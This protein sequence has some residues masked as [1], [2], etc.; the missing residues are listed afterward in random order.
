MKN[1]RAIRIKAVDDIC[2]GDK[3][4]M[5]LGVL[6]KTKKF[7][8]GYPFEKIRGFFDRSDV[9]LGNFEGL[10]TKKVIQHGPTSLTFCGLPEFA[11]K[12]AQTGFTVL[13]MANNHTLEHEPEI[14]E[15]TIEILQKNGINVCCLRS[16]SGRYY[17]ISL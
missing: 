9:V 7:G 11:R 6:S 12:L 14:F 1:R 8:V 16:N 10:L 15:E 5:G 4:I 17:S 13:N 3:Y 2:P